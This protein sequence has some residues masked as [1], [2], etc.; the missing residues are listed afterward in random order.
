MLKAIDQAGADRVAINAQ[1]NNFGEYDGVTG[2]ATFD[3]KGD[4]HKKMRRF[5][6]VNQQFIEQK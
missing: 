1:L 5:R 2:Q 3:D 6:V 4:T